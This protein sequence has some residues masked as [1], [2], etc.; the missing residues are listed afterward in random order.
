MKK[1]IAVPAL[2]MTTLFERILLGE[3]P[4]HRRA[5]GKGWYAF[6][7]IFPVERPHAR[8]THS[9]CSA[10][11]GTHAEEGAQLMSRDYRC[12]TP[13]RISIWNHGFH[14]LPS[15]WTAGRTG[16]AARPCA[17]V[18]SHGG[19]WWWNTDGH[20]ADSISG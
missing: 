1:D 17:R 16:S 8:D 5:K 7:D 3:I 11:G 2:C 15:R 10:F 13:I 19:R 12:S 18:A 20:V 4:S 14:G 6:L 9:P